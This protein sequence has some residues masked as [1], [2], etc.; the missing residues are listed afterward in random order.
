MYNDL[1][2]LK[3]KLIKSDLDKV[4]F[5]R[6][7]DVFISGKSVR[8]KTQAFTAT[9][10]KDFTDMFT[11]LSEN[12]SEETERLSDLLNENNETLSTLYEIKNAYDSGKL[13]E[14]QQ[15]QYNLYV[16]KLLK[17]DEDYKEFNEL[18]KAKLATAM[19]EEPLSLQEQNE[20]HNALDSQTE[21]TKEE[22]ERQLKIEADKTFFEKREFEAESKLLKQERKKREK[23][24]KQESKY[25]EVIL[26]KSTLFVVVAYIIMVVALGMSLYSI[27]FGEQIMSLFNSINP[28]DYAKYLEILPDLIMFA[29]TTL[30]Y[31]LHFIVIG[32]IVSLL[33]TLNKTK[34]LSKTNKQLFDIAKYSLFALLVIIPLLT[35][36]FTN[37][38]SYPELVFMAIIY[39]FGSAF[40]FSALTALF[41]NGI[42]LLLFALPLPAYMFAM[43]LIPV[44]ALAILFILAMT[45]T[46]T[47]TIKMQK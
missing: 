12:M 30:E 5:E 22:M 26:P 2:K 36:F 20:L 10:S 34:K 11:K 13:N 1:T 7:L 27:F 14:E 23:K 35:I 46:N 9:E 40:I 17:S 38:N 44:L 28:Y 45:N 39:I 16:N 37:F 21:L 31:G 25:K 47:V 24:E 6:T 33:I 15:E 19:Y 41:K 3:E 8:S 43:T 42:L 32:V 18:E 29:M 4:A